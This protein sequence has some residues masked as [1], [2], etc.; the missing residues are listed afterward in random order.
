MANHKNIKKMRLNKTQSNKRSALS[1]KLVNNHEV[2]LVSEVIDMAKK[3]GYAVIPL[4]KLPIYSFL[5]IF[6]VF[7]TIFSTT[8]VM[9]Q[10]QAPP[11]IQGGST[12]GMSL[13]V[14][15]FDVISQKQNLSLDVHVFNTS[16]GLPVNGTITAC[17]LHLYNQDEEEILRAVMSHDS[18]NVPNEWGYNITPNNFISFGDYAYTVQCN[19]T[20]IGGYETVGFRV[21][22]TVPFFLKLDLTSTPVM[23]VTIGLLILGVILVFSGQPILTTLGAAIW[24]IT[25]TVYLMNNV[26]LLISLLILAI[27]VSFAFIPSKGGSR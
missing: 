3:L 14:N 2:V 21:G 8:G 17:Y 12:G 5:F 4:K 9:A 13:T 19:D 18:S 11:F 27:G 25:G 10:A 1:N 7:L 16:T 23:A 15:P 26:S 20:K 22:P 6:A 24:V